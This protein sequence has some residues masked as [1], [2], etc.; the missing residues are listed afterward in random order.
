M[1]TGKKRELNLLNPFKIFII[2]FF[3]GAFSLY[4]V[5]D[6]HLGRRFIYLKQEI[7]FFRQI[8]WFQI[9]HFMFELNKPQKN[10]ITPMRTLYPDFGQN[11]LIKIAY[12][13][14]L[15]L[16][17]YLQSIKKFNLK[18]IVQDISILNAFFLKSKINYKFL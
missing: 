16:F 9:Q 2:F 14:Q 17:Y 7:S 18:S 4:T 1:F 12:T 8:K 5:Y 10:I 13:P 3:S 15:K 6:A 11:K